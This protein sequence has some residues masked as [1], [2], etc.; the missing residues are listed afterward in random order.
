[1]SVPVYKNA[2]IA[3][4][5]SGS[6]VYLVGVSSTEEGRLEA[7][8]VDLSNINSPSA[9]FLGSRTDIT[10]W[11]STAPKSCF[12]YPGNTAN[13]NSPITVQQFGPKSYLTNVYTNGTIEV[14]SYFQN[15]GYISPKLFSM[16]GAVGP[17]TWFVGVANRTSLTTNSAWN[18]LRFNTTDAGV[19]A[20]LDY[21]ISQ[22]PTGNPLVSVGTYTAATNTPVQGYNVVFDSA[23]GGVIYN[24]LNSASAQ[25]GDR[26]MTLSNAV[27]VD[28][29]GITLTSNAIPVTMVGVAYI[30]DQASNG[31]TVLYSISPGT[32]NKLTRVALT[33]NVPPFSPSMVASALNANIVVYGS[34]DSSA[35]TSSFNMFD[36]ISKGWSGPGLVVPPAPPST[37]SGPSPT[38]SGKPSESGE[39][40]KSNTG[41]IVGG[42]VAAV[43][44][45]AAIVFFVI[46][47]RRKNKS[48]G[49]IVPPAPSKEQPSQE[50]Y[51][52]HQ[53]QQQQQQQPYYPSSPVP[54]QASPTVFQTT[55][56]QQQPY[57]YTPPTLQAVPHQSQPQIFR[58]QSEIAGSQGAYS[59][60][61]YSPSSGGAISP[62]TP[63]TPASMSVSSPHYAQQQPQPHY[64]GYAS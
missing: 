14:S 46:R 63:Y 37:T 64:Q 5:R 24:A 2:C 23:G 50:Q 1:M 59:H 29:N 41:A 57:N 11:S 31:A 16:T 19:M 45:I 6:S 8:T 48:D 56:Q 9:T 21:V 54:Q 35:L 15:T 33:G 36:T 61:G 55:Q 25:T 53:Q 47:N 39:G 58:P 3:P 38:T 27:D 28:M 34:S 20:N 32:S 7:Y 51:N 49:G 60:A 52:A 22:Y 44:V 17:Y 18:A 42:I 12:N 30:L 10:S 62:Q 13:A 4:V 40:S 43:V 26:I